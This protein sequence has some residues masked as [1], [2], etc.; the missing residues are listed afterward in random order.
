MGHGCLMKIR[1]ERRVAVGFLVLRS[2]CGAIFG[3]GVRK[4]L[5]DDLGCLW[6]WR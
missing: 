1:V 5:S 2:C 6:M 3:A 4:Y